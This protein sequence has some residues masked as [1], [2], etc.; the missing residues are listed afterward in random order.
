[1]ITHPARGPRLGAATVELAVL[2]PFLVF[3]LLVVWDFGRIFYYA[4]VVDG[5]ARAGAMYA[6]DPYGATMSPYATVEEAARAD[7]P[8]D[9]R[10]AMEVKT[11]VRGTDADGRYV[12]VTVVYHFTTVAQYPG[13]PDMDI[14]RTVRVRETADYPGN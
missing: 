7:A 3:L 12:E 8:S 5:C 11:P 6:C 13:I 4:Q 14:T 1:M 9:L 10:D 2:L